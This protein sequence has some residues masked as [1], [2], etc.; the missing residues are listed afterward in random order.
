MPQEQTGEHMSDQPSGPPAQHPDPTR[1]ATGDAVDDL[2]AASPADLPDGAGP[3]AGPPAYD[4]SFGR[5]APAEPSWVPQRSGA[6]PPRH[7][8]TPGSPPST[9]LPR[10]LGLRGVQA[11]R[12][13]GG[14]LQPWHV[15]AI[16]AGLLV[17]AGFWAFSGL[18]DDSDLATRAAAGPTRARPTVPSRSAVVP[19]VPGLTSPPAPRPP[20]GATTPTRSAQT[21]PPTVVRVPDIPVTPVPTDAKTIRFESYAAGGARVEVSLSDARHTRY[22]YPVRNAPVAFETA[23]GPNVSSNDYY[24]LR[25]RL[26]D[27]TGSGDRGAVS[28]RILVDGI[29]VTSQQGRGYAN[30][31]ISPYYDIQRR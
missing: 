12:P 28:C 16:V 22:D 26:Y 1:D 19:P 17:P 9:S 3:P 11:A 10:T 24:S 23:I 6:Q 8:P 25:V 30:C 2:G 18:A 14:R 27:P 21:S 20:S 5:E 13:V 15:L 4:S 7:V 29:V 31:Y